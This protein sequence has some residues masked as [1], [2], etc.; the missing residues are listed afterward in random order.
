MDRRLMTK[1]MTVVT[2]SAVGLMGLTGCKSSKTSD[3][4]LLVQ[5]NEQLRQQ[6]A[7]MD[8]NSAE[9]EAIRQQY[10]SVRQRLEAENRD[11]ASALDQMRN[12][13]AAGGSLPSIDGA[14]VSARGSDVVV[15]VAGDVLFASG[16]A[17]LKNDSKSTLNGVAN[18]IKSNYGSNTIRVEGY[19]DTDPIR[20]SKWGTNEALSAARALAVETYLVSRGIDADQVYSAAFGPAHQRGSKAQSRRVEIVVLDGNN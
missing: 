1:L 8:G 20:R 9:A 3:Y 4:D 16:S 15:T 12:Q 7:S 13:P 19:T 11:L 14:Q 17:D 18:A 6:L 2:M 10:E 5:E